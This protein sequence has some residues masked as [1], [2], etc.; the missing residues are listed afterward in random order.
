MNYLNKFHLY[1]R[2]LSLILKRQLLIIDGINSIYRFTQLAAFA[3]LAPLMG[4]FISMD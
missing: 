4:A 1:Y 3:G 2:S